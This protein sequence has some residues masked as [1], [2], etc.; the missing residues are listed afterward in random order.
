MYNFPEIL[1]PGDP[2]PMFWDDSICFGFPDGG[3]IFYSRKDGNW[4]DVGTWETVNGELRLP[5]EVDVVYVRHTVVANVTASVKH[6]F[7]SGVLKAANSVTLSVLGNIQS[8]GIVDFTASNIN[9]ML[10][11]VNNLVSNFIS[12]NSTITYARAGN[13]NV[14]NLSYFNLSVSG[15]GIKFQKSSEPIQGAL[16]ISGLAIYEIGEYFL[17]VLGSTFITNSAM[18]T[19][20]VT[21]VN[22]VLFGGVLDIHTDFF[23]SIDFSIT[24][25]DVEVRRGV[26]IGR[27][28]RNVIL[29]RPGTGDWKVTANQTFSTGGSASPIMLPIQNLIIDSGV[30]LTLSSM[31]L[32]INGHLNGT[33]S[34]SKFVQI[35]GGS[36]LL[37]GEVDFMQTGSLELSGGAVVYVKNGDYELPLTNYAS[38]IILGNGVR[39]IK[40][41]LNIS[42]T[43]CTGIL[44]GL[45]NIGAGGDIFQPLT[46]THLA[47]LELGDYNMTV[48][49]WSRLYSVL[50]K[51]GNGLVVFK[52]EVGAGINLQSN[53]LCIDFT[54]SNADIE[55]WSGMRIGSND[56]PIDYPS[57][58]LGGNG[59]LTVKRSFDWIATG[60]VSVQPIV[61]QSAT[62]GIFD[63]FILDSD[64][65]MRTSNNR[66]EI[67]SVL[68]GS[69]SGSVFIAQGILRYKGSTEPFK[70]GVLDCTTP[71]NIMQYF[72]EGPQEIKGG[73][74]STL[75][76][77]GS[78]VKKLM[79]NVTVLTSFSLTGEASV[80]LNGFTL[81]TP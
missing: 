60:N 15:S 48:G 78:G 39:T 17:Q 50:K 7:V 49:Q 5:R 13:Q 61:G 14:I 30:T 11:G 63:K 24:N 79:G 31:H 66:L 71:G 6:L 56:N 35:N 19:K 27:N 37:N 8:V 45:N 33:D 51:S 77:G 32:L 81:T 72:R 29:A 23:V 62:F 74:Y 67:Q 38:L 65:V 64:V 76:F 22:K 57:K 18:L 21:G 47:V 58:V 41:D 10:Y 25:P 73:L 26:S 2:Q 36:L 53:D 46:Q 42:E 80:D 54:G 16:R 40:G 4:N 34:G 20:S 59:Q 44:N 3:T 55:I 70:I 9:L 12:G 43:L 1:H 75:E 28:E 68:D 52:G 69:N